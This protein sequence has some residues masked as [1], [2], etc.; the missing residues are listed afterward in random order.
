ML[1]GNEPYLGNVP[2]AVSGYSLWLDGKDENSFTFSSGTLVSQWQDKSGNSNHF[3]QSTV[4]SQPS[5]E[6]S[7]LLAL[8]GD[9]DWLQAGSKFMN[10]VH[11]GGSNTFFIVG[12]PSS[13]TDWSPYL[14]TGWIASANVAFGI[15]YSSGTGKTRINIA[16][17]VAGTSAGD[18]LSTTEQSVNTLGIWTLKIDADA[19]A[20]SRA[21]HYF[22][23][24][25]AETSNTQTNPPSAAASTYNPGIGADAQGSYFAHLKVGE[26]VWYESN[27][28]DADRE[29]VRDGLMA[30]WG[31][32]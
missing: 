28:S 16:R 32:S 12:Y 26:I 6:A 1:V 14:T 27:L 17:G 25:A 19:S 7:G 30:K 2:P 10:N 3:S 13:T 9:D 22:N 23:T 24:G 11:N 15:S 20:G 5:R 29:A 8:D 31:I 18:S 4:A 21:I